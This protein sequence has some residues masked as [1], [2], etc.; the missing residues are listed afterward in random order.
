MLKCKLSLIMLPSGGGKIDYRL[1]QFNFFTVRTST[2][3]NNTE[4]ILQY[5]RLHEAMINAHSKH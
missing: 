1:M 2:K 4:F 5:L 3:I